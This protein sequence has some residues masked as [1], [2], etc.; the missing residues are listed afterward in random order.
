MKGRMWD[1]FQAFEDTPPDIFRF[2]RLWLFGMVLGAVNGILLFE[3]IMRELRF[4]G[5][6]KGL[7]TALGDI[8]AL[9][10][11]VLVMAYA[12]RHKSNVAKWLLAVPYNLTIL[13]FY[14]TC[15]LFVTD[16]SLVVVLSLAHL[17]LIA[18]ATRKLF[19]PASQVWFTGV[20]PPADEED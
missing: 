14:V 8:A 9:C 19:T 5:D 16:N 3:D 4:F 18:A 13:L 2:E 11:S 6:L 7:V 15:L 20:L 12:S 1:S 10:V 17:G